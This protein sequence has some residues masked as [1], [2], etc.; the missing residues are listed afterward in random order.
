VRRHTWTSRVELRAAVFD[1]IEVFYNRQR[2]HSSIGYKSPA[3]A[4]A[5][6]AIGLVA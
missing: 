5:E 4:E 3:Q 2:I 6:F 1:Y